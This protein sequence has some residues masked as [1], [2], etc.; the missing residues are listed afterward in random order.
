[1]SED[2]APEAIDA[3]ETDDV[4]VVAHSTEEE[5]EP[6]TCLTNNSNAL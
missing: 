3:T 1:M 5:E 2:K 4:E 6:G